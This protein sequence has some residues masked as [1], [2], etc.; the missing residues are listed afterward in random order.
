MSKKLWFYEEE[1]DAAD[2]VELQTEINE[3][4]G[5]YGERSRNVIKDLLRKYDYKRY[6]IFIGEAPPHTMNGERGIERL[7]LQWS[8]AYICDLLMDADKRPEEYTPEEIEG[9]IRAY[10]KLPPLM[11]ND[12]K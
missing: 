8:Q 5:E 10:L 6:G 4:F 3:Y 1:D 7:N 2:A 9:S 11:I 12:G